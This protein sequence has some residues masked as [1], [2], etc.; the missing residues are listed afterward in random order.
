VRINCAALAPQLLES[1]LFGHEKGA[2]TGATQP[3]PG[4]LESARGGTAFLDEVGELP[5]ALQAKLLRALETK[6]VLRVGAVRPKAIDVRFV[7]A[8]NRDLPAEVAR[9]QFRADL[10]FRLDGVTLAIP[11]LRERRHLIVPLALR[12]LVAAKA[13]AASTELAVSVLQKL[14]A[15]S[16]PGNVRELKA[17]VE[18]ALL[19][20]R[21]KAISP[22]HIVLRPIGA[23]SSDPALTESAVTAALTADEERERARIVEA[24][25][26]CGGNQT[27][28][29][30]Q[31]GISRATMVTRLALYRIPRPRKK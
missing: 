23:P 31:L 2:F 16:W 17:V 3:K 27:R 15:H 11:P 13:E 26:A 19:L 25:E 12:F 28:A 1:E 9:E 21:G 4:L 14:E 20:A 6:E 8:T 5:A 10:F 24:L 22:S 29:A 30:R 18:R 7:A